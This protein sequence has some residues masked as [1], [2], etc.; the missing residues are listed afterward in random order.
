MGLLADM[1]LGDR[2]DA[3]IRTFSRGMRQRLGISRALINEPDVL[4]LDEPTLGLDP[5]GQDDVLRHVR[6][7]ATERG[8][9]VILTSHLLDEVNRICDRV[10]ILNKGRVVSTGSVD[11]VARQAGVARSVCARVAL[12]DVDRAVAR[13][14]DLPDTS[15]VQRVV[16]RPGEIRVDRSRPTLASQSPPLP[17]DVQLFGLTRIGVVLTL[18][19]SLLHLRVLA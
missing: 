10:V 15:S 12:A 13:L 7:T 4:F 6:E 14:S 9:A 16:S 8:I 3:R 18:T 5:A 2:A 19:S 11:E 17:I 1:G